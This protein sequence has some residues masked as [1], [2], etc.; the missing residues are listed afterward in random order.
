VSAEY[1]VSGIEH[2]DGAK[3][4]SLRRR[5]SFVDHTVEL[6]RGCGYRKVLVRLADDR[7]VLVDVED[8]K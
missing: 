3:N 2:A 1:L 8:E 6:L 7:E 4:V 5:R